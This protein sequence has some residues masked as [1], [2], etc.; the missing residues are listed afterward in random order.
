MFRSLA[1]M[2]HFLGAT[3]LIAGV[4]SAGNEFCWTTAYAHCGYHPCTCD[5]GSTTVGCETATNHGPT[6]NCQSGSED[7]TPNTWTCGREV[8]YPPGTSCSSCAGTGSVQ[9]TFCTKMH[10]CDP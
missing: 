6:G 8:Y 1:F 3:C 2:C 5:T 4:V 7:C 9:T 10:G